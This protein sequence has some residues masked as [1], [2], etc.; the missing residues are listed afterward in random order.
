M[1]TLRRSR[2]EIMKWWWLISLPLYALDQWTKTM[3]LR[4]ISTSEVVPVI[5]G[6]FNLVQVHNTGAAIGMLSDSNLFFIFLASAALIVLFVLIYRG[7]FKDRLSQCAA[8]LL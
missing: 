2:D 6:F 4:S 7:A 3:V 5:P 8:A 1:R